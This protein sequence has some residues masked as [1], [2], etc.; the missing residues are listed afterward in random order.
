MPFGAILGLAG[1]LLGGRSS[2]K[3][4]QTQADAQTD[5]ARLAADEARFRPL[6]L[7]TRF[8]R[9]NF[10]YGP[11]G[12]VT[13]ASYT[14]DPQL[15]GMQDRFLGLAGQGLSQAEM[16]QQQFAP[17]QGAA[18]GLFGLGQQYLGQPADQRLGGIA[19]QYLGAQPDFGVGQ[20][21]Q[22]LL[23]QGQ[24]QQLVDIARQ[25]FGA[26][27][28][29]IGTRGAEFLRQGQD[30]QLVDIAR[31][32]LGPSAG[33][34]ALTSL[35]QQYVAQSP[36][37][38]AQQFMSQQQ[39]LLAPS[40]ERQFAQL[41]NQ[42]F[43]TGRGGLS[44]G[45][46]GERPSGAAGLGAASPE[47]EAYYNALAQQD[48]G[49][50]AQAQQA[51]QQQ[52]AFGAGLL[53]QGQA[54]G[55][56][57]LGFGADLLARQQ[58]AEAARVGLGAE[59][60][61]QQQA[62]GQGQIGFGAGLLSQQ[63]AQEA[64]RLGLGSAFT[65]QQQ[66]LEQGRFGF[67]ADL[68]GRQQAMEQGRT[69][70]GAGLF[71]TGGNLL[72]QGYGGQTA[73]LGPYQAYLQGATGLEALGQDPLNLG[74]ALG[75]RIANPAGGQALLQGGMGAAQSQ[76]AANAYN[77]FATALTGLSQNPALRNVTGSGL[78]AA[79]SQTALGG[80]GFGTGLA[81]G[82]QDIGAFI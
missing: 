61:A 49:L 80:S 25:Q 76:F 34:Q 54:L 24:D 15:R 42:L 33:A 71:G 23:G 46:T 2:K 16:A 11:D 67:G 1:G 36:Q 35:G 73:A 7:T 63:Q 50:A 65:A 14:L 59:L 28:T 37:E 68:L 58:A 75:G 77:P 48:A 70:F 21:G 45:A 74:S 10:R 52:T 41:Q 53:G 69:S 13:G 19:S 57:Q 51:G 29:D 56:S 12:R 26:V 82:N 18:Q 64:Q 39:N 5:A 9:S 44:V 40:R 66:A 78:Q 3:A 60:T 55:Q 4:A 22:R 17:L 62:L 43:Q 79:F 47:L 32:Q 31:Q 81:Y 72:T 27:P 20:I 6:G 30:Q 8:G 38:A